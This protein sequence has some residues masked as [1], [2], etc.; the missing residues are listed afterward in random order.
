M[1]ATATK[2]RAFSVGR[3]MQRATEIMPSD[4]LAVQQENDV[5]THYNTP[6]KKKIEKVNRTSPVSCVDVVFCEQRHREDSAPIHG[7][8]TDHVGRCS[9]R[10]G[11]G[12]VGT[13]DEEVGA[14]GGKA[15][16]TG[17]GNVGKMMTN[18]L[19]GRNADDERPPFLN[20]RT[21]NR[22]EAG[23]SGTLYKNAL[24]VDA[25]WR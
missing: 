15:C 22:R 1:I 16:R 23:A 21:L 2:R 12:N 7:S 13:Q 3:M 18:I 5:E 8:R 11:S 24:L 17:N 14:T 6:S 19:G 10:R 25:S 9:S 20:W 4:Q